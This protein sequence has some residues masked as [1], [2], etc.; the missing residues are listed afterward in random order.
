MSKSKA[1]SRLI[2]NALAKRGF[3]EDQGAK[4]VK[5][6]QGCL[7]RWIHGHTTPQ[8]RHLRGIANLT[9]LSVED[10]VEVY[11]KATGA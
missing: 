6:S 8:L 10:L 2:R 11:E 5:C 3:S 4:L 1:F 9:G 7:N